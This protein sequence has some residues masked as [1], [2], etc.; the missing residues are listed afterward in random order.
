MA[1]HHSS[2]FLGGILLGSALGAVAGLLAAPRT[3]QD[4]RR[5]LKKSAEALPELAEDLSS[6]L[7]LHAHNLSDAAQHRWAG[8]LNRLQAA[9]AAGVQ[10]SQETANDLND[11]K[12]TEAPAKV[13][14]Q[15]ES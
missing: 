11:E 1:K 8:T 12:P 4:T 3:G 9:I 10:V 2:S 6:T 7:N 15:S 5:I 13:A 14:V